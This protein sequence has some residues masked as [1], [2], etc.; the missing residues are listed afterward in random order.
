M[1]ATKN[2]DNAVGF[3]PSYLKPPADY[4]NIKHTGI[5]SYNEMR[6]KIIVLIRSLHSTRRRKKSRK[7]SV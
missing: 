3:D 4:L 7:K 2:I 6:V 5:Q 1:E